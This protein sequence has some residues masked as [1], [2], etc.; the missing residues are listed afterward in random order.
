VLNCADAM[1]N[2]VVSEGDEPPGTGRTTVFEKVAVRVFPGSAEAAREL[3]GE[4]RQ[5]VETR[6]AEGRNAVLGLATGSTPVP[7]YR[8]LVRLHREEGLSF[9]NVVTFNLDEYFGIGRDHPESYRRFMREQL[10]DHIDVPEANIH[11]P[12]GTVPME[13]VFA[14]CAAYERAIA[15]AGGIDLQVL[16][17]GR[18]GHIG[19]NEPGST[20]DSRTRL[21]AL[22]R[23]TR[24]DAA[25]DFLGEENVPR[26]A[27]TMGVGTILEARRVV[28]MAWGENKADIVATAVEGPQ[29]D[30]VS[31]SFLQCHRDA[32]FFTDEPAA[33]S[34]TRFHTPWRVGPVE[35][36][37]AE[38]R[39]AV[40]WLA[41][42]EGK[43]VPSL[44]TKSTTRTGW[45][46]SSP[47]TAGTPT[48]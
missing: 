3:A 46:N 32:R 12:D 7:F 40:I 28:L 24:R 47:G 14:H 38:S 17:I 25:P 43:P 21:I 26:F 8:E 6:A 33:K 34:L 42:L 45:A 16:G 18:T 20:R 11:L 36:D 15:E 1:V 9:A 10:F 13:A 41:Q 5:L 23:V 2:R 4:V 35:W 31:A 48:S 22:D 30:A 39:R 44:S 19:F 29:T 37:E 27:I